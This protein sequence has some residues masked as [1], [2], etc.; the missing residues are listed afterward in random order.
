MNRLYS[1]EIVFRGHP[2]KVCDQIAGAILD[3]I[4]AYDGSLRL[5]V[6]C[7][8]NPCGHVDKYADVLN[9]AQKRLKGDENARINQRAL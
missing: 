8:D 6:D 4:L 3:K 1:N 5:E 9:E 2:D 7:W